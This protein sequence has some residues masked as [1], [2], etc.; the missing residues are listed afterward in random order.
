MI[1]RTL[2]IPLLIGKV[3]DVIRRT[4]G[5]FSTWTLQDTS[6]AVAVADNVAVDLGRNVV[7]NGDMETGD[8]PDNWVTSGDGTISSEGIIIHSG[9]A[10][11]K[12][13][14]GSTSGIGD[15][16][17]Y[18]QAT[19]LALGSD[20]IFDAWV[21]LPSTGGAST[22][23]ILAGTSPAGGFVPE[24]DSTTITDTW[25][26]LTITFTATAATMYLVVVNSTGDSPGDISYCDDV[27]LKQTDILASSAYSTPGDNPLD[28]DHTGVAVGQPGQ[29]NVQY[30]AEYDGIGAVTDKTSAEYNSVYDATT[31]FCRSIAVRKSTWDTTERVI[32]YDYVDANN[33][34]KVYTSTTQDQIVFE[35]MAGGTLEQITYDSNGSTDMMLLDCG[36]SGSNF[37]ARV[38]AAVVGTEA[39]AGTFVGNFTLNLLGAESTTPTKVHLGDLAYDQ[40]YFEYP[41]DSEMQRIV[42]SMG[43]PA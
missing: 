43:I 26:M 31:D 39:I 5:Y 10:S 32:F 37:I 36:R 13:V 1:G 2:L 6:G 35:F 12:Y 21:H 24:T 19:G 28:G 25:V 14:K 42:D 15:R 11:L 3:L 27:T 41:S 9:S 34:I 20:Y 40:H 38:N 8:P 16:S 33:Y 17:F 18:Y 30:V 23:Q 22:A 4:Y 29:F 7:I